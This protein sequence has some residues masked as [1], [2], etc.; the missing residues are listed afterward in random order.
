[1]SDENVQ[2]EL[3]VEFTEEETGGVIKE[4][5]VTKV[6]V[7]RK[8]KKLSKKREKMAKESRKRSR[9]KH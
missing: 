6:G 4:K 7:T 2:V 9:G 5:P 8:V 3:P 1:M